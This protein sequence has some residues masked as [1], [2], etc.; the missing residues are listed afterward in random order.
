MRVR[1]FVLLVVGCVAQS[2]AKAQEGSSGAAASGGQD[3]VSAARPVRRWSITVDTGGTSGGP[4]R[5]IE[6]A[7]RAAHL[8]DASP[9]LGSPVGHP[10]SNTGFAAIGFPAL[11]EVRY[12]IR[13]FWSLGVLFSD[14]PIGATLGYREPSHYL[15]V[16][17]SVTSVAAMLSA[18]QRFFQMGLGPALHVARARPGGNSAQPPPW[19]NSSKLGFIAQARAAVPAGSRVFLDLT[20]QYRFVGRV[21]VGP[22]ASSGGVGFPVTFPP[23]GVQYNHWF[24]GVG[25][26]LRF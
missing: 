23:T 14:T 2:S 16:D 12:R 20:L 10:F 6:D 18:G 5:D 24:V 22:Y 19:S 9:G 8:D 15:S 1:L 17:H 3:S 26:G 21:V 25:T 13:E 11:I 4:A 7:M